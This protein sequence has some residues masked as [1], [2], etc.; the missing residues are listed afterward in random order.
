MS[1]ARAPSGGRA[2]KLASLL[3][4][5]RST[6]GLQP[7]L[8][9]PGTSALAPTGLAW[10]AR[11]PYRLGPTV[12]ASPTCGVGRGRRGR[13]WSILKPPKTSTCASGWGRSRRSAPRPPPPQ[14]RS[15]SDFLTP[16]VRFGLCLVCITELDYVYWSE[17]CFSQFV[18]CPRALPLS[19]PIRRTCSFSQLQN[20]PRHGS[21][22]IFKRRP[23]GV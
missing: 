2:E 6:H 1:L 7:S 5:L 11:H 23:F 9:H 19:E 12:S 20:N 17:T 10:A 16:R 4:R 22:T 18:I 14:V 21:S 13:L 8:C 15:Q 3:T